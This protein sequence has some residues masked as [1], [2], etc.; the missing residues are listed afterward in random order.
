MVYLFGG[1]VMT[2]KVRKS[3]FT[4]KEHMQFLELYA[5]GLSERSLGRKFGCHPQTIRTRAG[6]YGLPLRENTQCVL[7]TDGY[8]AAQRAHK[9]AARNAVL[10]EIIK[11][12]E[13]TYRVEVPVIHN[14]SWIVN[15]ARPALYCEAPAEKG[16]AYCT[17]HCAVVYRKPSAWEAKL[18]EGV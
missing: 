4:E 15:S 3:V 12:P 2:R 14:C 17:E 13:T 1:F 8:N 5:A 6:K 18:L 11:P 10:A 16:K 7:K 9:V